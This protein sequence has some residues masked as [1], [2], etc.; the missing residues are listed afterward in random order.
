MDLFTEN[1]EKSGIESVSGVYAPQYG[2][3][4]VRSFFQPLAGAGSVARGFQTSYGTS[5]KERLFNIR[6]R[7][8]CCPKCLQ[9]SQPLCFSHSVFRFWQWGTLRISL[10]FLFFLSE[11]NNLSCRKT[12]TQAEK[13]WQNKVNK[14]KSPQFVWGNISNLSAI[15]LSLHECDPAVPNS[16]EEQPCLHW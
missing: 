11:R 10:L 2:Y 14:Q 9:R 16:C 1:R 3:F 13:S 8:K 15:F 4:P 7:K 6:L 5:R 12:F